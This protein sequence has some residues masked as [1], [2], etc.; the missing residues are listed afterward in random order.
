MVLTGFTLS[1]FMKA[2]G[3]YFH[4]GNYQIRILLGALF[5]AI[6]ADGVITMYL[7]GNGYGREGNP[8]MEYWLTEDKMIILKICGGLLAGLCLWSAYRRKP[9]L[10]VTITSVLLSVYVL[11]IGWN[12][13]FLL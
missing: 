5:A 12:L 4:Q 10:S 11:I 6:V 1:G 7:V 13:H 8:F 9:N 3:N 2:L